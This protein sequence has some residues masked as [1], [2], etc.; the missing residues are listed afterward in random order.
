[1]MEEE[2]LLF[3]DDDNDTLLTPPVF[4]SFVEGVKATTADDTKGAAK[5]ICLCRRIFL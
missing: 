3:H 5:K 4:R 2:A 1:M